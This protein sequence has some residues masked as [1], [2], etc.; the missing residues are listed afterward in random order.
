MPRF[1]KPL[2][3]T[4][5]SDVLSDNWNRRYGE[6]EVQQFIDDIEANPD[7][8]ISI[9]TKDKDSKFKTVIPAE[10]KDYLLSKLPKSPKAPTDKKVSKKEVSPEKKKTEKI[11]DYGEKEVPGVSKQPKEEDKGHD[12]FFGRGYCLHGRY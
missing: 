11:E 5:S 9:E 7:A 12:S 3:L 2:S 1:N 6:K 10:L 4:S 8:E